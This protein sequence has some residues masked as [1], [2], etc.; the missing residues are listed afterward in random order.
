MYKRWKLND[1][2]KIAYEISAKEAEIFFLRKF[3][4]IP[5]EIDLTNKKTLAKIVTKIIKHKDPIQ[6]I[7]IN[8]KNETKENKWALTGRLDQMGSRYF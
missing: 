5:D 6:T 8:N 4:R 2:E 3:S 1:E 7:T